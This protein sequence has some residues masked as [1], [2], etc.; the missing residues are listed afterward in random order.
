M[1]A[2]ALPASAYALDFNGPSDHEQLMVELVNRARLDPNGEVARI[3]TTAGQLASGTNGSSKQALA[4]VGELDLAAQRHSADMLKNDYF[5]HTSEDGRSPWERMADAGYTGYRTAG[6]NIAWSSRNGS[7]QAS[8]VNWLHEGLWESDGHQRNILNGNFSEIGV[9]YVAGADQLITQKFGD[10]G[11]SYLTGV[12]ID[13]ADNDDFY[14]IGE[15]QGGVRITA[16]NADGAFATSTWDAGGYSL[17][18]EAGTYTVRFEGGDLDGFYE[19]TVTIGSSNV[20]LD[21]IEG[22]MA[23]PGVA[24]DTILVPELASAPDVGRVSV[25]G[26]TNGRDVISGSNRNEKF[27]TK[28]GNDKV[29]AKGGHDVINGGNGNDSLYGDKGRD[30]VSGQSGKDRLYGGSHDDH[31]KGGNN[32]DRLY[33]DNG[34]DF[35]VG[36]KGDDQMWGGSGADTFDLMA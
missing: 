24:A 29:T 35:L 17:A 14:D 3:G 1:S 32:N 4:V 10:R 18:L 28:N 30:V 22:D 5:S 9:G 21:V 6:E 27:S 20:K 15:G 26:A 11:Y 2:P 13:D 12:V 25:G 34:D 33:G 31:L 16:W 8:T 23:T 36:G 19:T 7:E